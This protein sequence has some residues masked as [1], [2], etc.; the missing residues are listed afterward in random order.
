VPTRAP[1]PFSLSLS[2]CCALPPKNIFYAAAT[3]PHCTGV[4][5]CAL[6]VP[7]SVRPP[8]CSHPFRSDECRFLLPFIHFLMFIAFESPFCG[9]SRCLGNSVFPLLFFLS[10][11]EMVGETHKHLSCCRV[12]SATTREVSHKIFLFRNRHQPTSNC[13]CPNKCQRSSPFV[14]QLFAALAVTPPNS[15]ELLGQAA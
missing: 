13:Q 3:G 9:K 2:F 11:K 1:P 4:C 10:W 6:S 5:V 7:V 12:R 8:E 14:P 15:R